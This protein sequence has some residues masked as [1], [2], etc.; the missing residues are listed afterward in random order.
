MC[1]SQLMYAR[2]S[3]LSCLCAVTCV[4]AFVMPL[5][6]APC[7]VSWWAGGR[8]QAHRAAESKLSRV[9][10]TRSYRNKHFILVRSLCAQKRSPCL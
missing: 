3:I 10:L 2:C 9:G 4:V 7:H 1:L 6:H 5:P 8:E